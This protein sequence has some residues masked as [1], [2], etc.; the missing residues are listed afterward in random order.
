MKRERKI[1]KMKRKNRKENGKKTERSQGREK[2][3]RKKH[4]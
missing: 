2:E 3:I 1:N 4:R